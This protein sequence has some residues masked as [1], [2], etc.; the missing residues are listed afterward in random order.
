MGMLRSIFYTGG[1]LWGKVFSS[2]AHPVTAAPDSEEELNEEEREIQRQLMNIVQRHNTAIKG[3]RVGHREQRRA[4]AEELAAL[5]VEAEEFSKKYPIAGI[6]NLDQ[7][8]KVARQALCESVPLYLT[9]RDD[10]F[11]VCLV[12]TETTGVDENDEPI[13]VALMLVEITQKLGDHVG[14]IDRYL[15]FRVPNVPIHPKAQRVHGLTLADLEGKSLDME[16]IY[17]IIDSA[18]VLIAHNADF[19]SR[20][21]S[22][23]ISGIGSRQW[24]CSMNDLYWA[25]KELANG[26]KGLDYICQKLGVEKNEQHDAMG[27]VEALYKVLMTRTGITNRSQ[28]LL[29]RLVKHT[30]KEY[31][32]EY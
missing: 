4:K 7:V 3:L 9:S 13:S 20:M 32:E 19:D 24:G 11:F 21:M 22:K 28:T 6:T 15:G 12:D 1:R 14:E 10:T 2:P 23:I 8:R 5:V 29:A 31:G 16:R 26:R 17:R 30:M 27:D 25:W 18:E